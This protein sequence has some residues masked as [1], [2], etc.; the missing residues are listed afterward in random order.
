MFTLDDGDI[1]DIKLWPFLEAI[2]KELIE[3]LVS[4]FKVN[5]IPCYCEDSIYFYS[6]NGFIFL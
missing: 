6:K 3:L 4:Y 1:Q 2:I 5:N